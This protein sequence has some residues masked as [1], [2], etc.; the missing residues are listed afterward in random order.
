MDFKSVTFPVALV[1]T[2]AAC[3]LLAAGLQVP[4]GQATVRL[5]GG[6]ARI[7]VGTAA[8]ILIALGVYLEFVARRG[9]SKPKKVVAGASEA[10][11]PFGA[12]EPMAFND[13][14]APDWTDALC[15][16]EKVLVK[17]EGCGWRP[18][19]ILG[20]GR[21]G[22]IWGGWLAGNL[23][24]LPIAVVDILYRDTQSGRLVT[25]PA[26]T[27]VLAA[28]QEFYGT[29]LNVL[30]VEGATSTGQTIVE[31]MTQFKRNVTGWD[32]KIAILYKNRTVATRVDFAGGIL[33]PWPASLPWHLRSVYRPHMNGNSNA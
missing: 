26:G 4:F 33:E 12:K 6:F 17:I 19:L 10:A 27:Q 2:G 1:L 32:V 11:E 24:S 29:P 7:G 21:S 8:V 3:L 16:A 31:F 28:L 15:M 9:G 13:S 18:N 5:D 23:G 20:L 22:A 25:F 30:V 14:A